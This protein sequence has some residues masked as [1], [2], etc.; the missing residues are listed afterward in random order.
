MSRYRLSA[1]AIQD[2]DDI[3][4]YVGQNSQQAADNLFDKLRKQFSILAKFPHLGRLRPKLASYLRSFS[5]GSYIIFYRPIEEGIEI[6]RVVHGSRDIEQIFQVA[7]DTES[8][9]T[10]E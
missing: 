10:Q 8:K 2:I 1:Q 9:E 5:V 6:V 3:W 7:E 4:N